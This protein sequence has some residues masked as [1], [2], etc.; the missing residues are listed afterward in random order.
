L[1]RPNP[2]IVIGG[3]GEQKTLPLVARYA[4]GCNLFPSPEIPRKLEILRRH[5]EAEGRD[6][7]GIEKT[8]MY[9]FDASGG[10]ASVDEAIRT[11]GWLASLGIQTTYIG[12]VDAHQIT[13]LEIVAE[14]VL[15][16]VADL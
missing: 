6:Y 16:A 15:P 11:L 9:T 12:V 1:S 14:R 4:D 8:S 10:E 3:S 7:A 5:C 13:P 2:P